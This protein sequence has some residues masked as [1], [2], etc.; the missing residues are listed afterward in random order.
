MSRIALLTFVLALSISLPARAGFE[1]GYAAYNAKDWKAA[2]LNLRPAAEAGDDRAMVVLGNMYAEGMGVGWDA[3]EA[4]ALYNRAAD[5]GNTDAM[6]A[7]GATYI[8]G[9]GVAQSYVT[10]ADWF[11]RAAEAGSQT[12]AFFYAT[13]ILRGNQSATD[14]L[15]SDPYTAYKWF[16][17][18]ARDGGDASYQKNAQ[19]MAAA[20][21]KKLLKPAETARADKE[22]AAWKP[23]VAGKKE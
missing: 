2:I 14:D 17:I 1:E 10:G 22:A 13:T 19:D 20:V 23:A 11:R 8:N 5:K 16:K 21:A 4:L 7:I 6:L 12:G 9:D 15:K 18:A 3:Q